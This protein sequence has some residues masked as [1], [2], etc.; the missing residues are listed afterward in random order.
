MKC[1]S[2][3]KETSESVQFPCPKCGEKI[4]R[5]KRCRSLSLEYKCP[6]CG[7]KGP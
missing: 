1:I 5:C 6:K 4:L 2:C 7:Y 3:E